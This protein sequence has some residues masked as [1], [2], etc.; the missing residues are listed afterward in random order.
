MTGVK[1]KDVIMS[2]VEFGYTSLKETEFE[3]V[4]FRGVDIK[5]MDITEVN[6]NGG[7]F[8]E[9]QIQ[10]LKEQKFDLFGTSV[11]I[12][13]SEDIISYEKYSWEKKKDYIHRRLR[14]E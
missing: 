1:F 7:I 2:E 6:L 14:K 13:D 3:N 8:N 4:D 11:N 12:K 10:Y 5:K 9:E